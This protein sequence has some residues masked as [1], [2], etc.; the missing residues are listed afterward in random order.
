METSVQ[1]KLEVLSLFSVA[2]TLSGTLPGIAPDDSLGIDGIVPLK[3]FSAPPYY[4][5][6]FSH[7]IDKSG[8]ALFSG[9]IP[10]P[11]TPLVSAEK[12]SLEQS[13]GG[14]QA[15][16]KT[17]FAVG[18][19]VEQINS[20]KMQQF[21]I[22][23]RDPERKGGLFQISHERDSFFQQAEKFIVLVFLSFDTVETFQYTAAQICVPGKCL[24]L[25]VNTVKCKPFRDKEQFFSGS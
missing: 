25:T 19:T 18:K 10:Q 13:D 15:H 22:F 17:F 12:I 6:S 7:K 24:V 2:G 9:K 8:T 5:F 23:P 21:H 14:K 4:I 16:E 3:I 1:K 20:C 11:G